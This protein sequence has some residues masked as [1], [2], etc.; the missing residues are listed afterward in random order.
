VE[1][2]VARADAVLAILHELAMAC[3]LPSETCAAARQCHQQR[4][5]LVCSFHSNLSWW[6]G[7][8]H[9]AQSMH[10]VSAL[11]SFVVDI[12]CTLLV[13]AYAVSCYARAWVWTL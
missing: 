9:K 4:C 5:K 8:L 11:K 12:R 2:F 1:R 6:L 7:T 3:M 13:M 10:L